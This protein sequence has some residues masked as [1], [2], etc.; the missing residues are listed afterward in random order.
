VL[1]Y[2]L[3][4]RR[5]LFARKFLNIVGGPVV[6]AFAV[7][8]GH[9]GDVLLNMGGQTQGRQN[10]LDPG[11]MRDVGAGYRPM[12]SAGMLCGP[13]VGGDR[14][15]FAVGAVPPTWIAWRWPKY[16]CQDHP[17]DLLTIFFWRLAMCLVPTISSQRTPAADDDRA[18]RRCALARRLW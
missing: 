11:V 6:S 12:Q 3:P 15:A 17:R 5:S 1:A 18:G 9:R 4:N 2:V 14:H 7:Q 13:A 8:P 16:S 10:L